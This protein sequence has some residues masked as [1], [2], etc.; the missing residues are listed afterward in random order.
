MSKSV[1]W[2]LILKDCWLHSPMIIVAFAGGVIAL[3]IL[4]MG[5][6]TPTVL[7][8]VFFFIA[9]CFLACLLPM[10]NIVNERKKQNLP[11]LMS[12]PISS[13]DY[14]TA[15]LISTVGM[16]LVPWLTLILAAVLFLAIRH[17]LPLGI[18]PQVLM[19]GGL[20]FIGFCLITGAAI[21]GESEAWAVAALAIVNSSYWL[22]WYLLTAHFPGLTRDWSSKMPVWNS[23]V[24]N[25]LAGEFVSVVLIL[26][27]TYYL[28]SRKRSFV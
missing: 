9:L 6:E 25:T 27:L 3:T 21:V 16:F 15:K 24:R 7:G 5:G 1:V 17:V 4:M 19:I 10:S 8:C 28:Q 20:P 2:K 13:V 11:F 23:A 22:T 14:A 26:G 12:L 18:I